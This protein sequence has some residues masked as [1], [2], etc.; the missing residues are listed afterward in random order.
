MA[1][2]HASLEAYRTYV[3]LDGSTVMRLVMGEGN[4]PPRKDCI[5]PLRPPVP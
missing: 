1:S 4:P 3:R 5:R 2:G